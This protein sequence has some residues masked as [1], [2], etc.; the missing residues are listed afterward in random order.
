MQV[1]VAAV[2]RVLEQILLEDWAA[3]VPAA[4]ELAEHLLLVFLV[5]LTPVVEEEQADITVLRVQAVMVVVE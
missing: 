4:A 1:A 5:L 3:A 2:H